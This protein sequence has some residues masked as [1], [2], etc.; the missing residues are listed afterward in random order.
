[1]HRLPHINQLNV[2]VTAKTE[3]EEAPTKDGGLLS[4]P[5]TPPPIRPTA[6]GGAYYQHFDHDD[7]D[8]PGLVL[9]VLIYVGKVRQVAS[10]GDGAENK[11]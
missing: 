3:D 4:A 8:P 6:S 7:P 9:K 10:G 5:P 2:L 11:G 1:M